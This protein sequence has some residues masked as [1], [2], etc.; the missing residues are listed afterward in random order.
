MGGII[1]FFKRKLHGEPPLHPVDR[2]AAKHYVK[3][4]LAHIFPELRNDPDAL[5]R[6]Y[7]ELTLE[8]HHGAGEGGETLF[9]AV[10]P[11]DVR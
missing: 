7:Q 4:R 8:P 9:E 6:A 5:E 11:G 3:Q 1:E 10:L 2:R